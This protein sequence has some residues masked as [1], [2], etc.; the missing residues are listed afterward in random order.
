[1]RA[2]ARRVY[3]L[4]AQGYDAGRPDYPERVY[5]VLAE[6]CGAGPGTSVLEIG[7]GTGRVT[8]RLLALGARVLS[9]EPDAEMARYL[10][11]A[12]AEAPVDVLVSSFE[13]ARL[14]EE[15]FDLVVAAMSFHWVDQDVGLA[16][17]RRVLR[18]GGS[19]ALWWTS[20][21]D[22]EQPDAY[23]RAT[24][25]LLATDDAR[26]ISQRSWE[27]D[28]PRRRDDLARRAGLVDVDGELIRW[29]LRLDSSGSGPSTGR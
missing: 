5:E 15:H 24:A 6:R 14:P 27:L 2:D 29:T 21:G 23:E 4:D 25:H 28:E 22:P 13:E 17:V 3:G 10:T 7:P 8:R 1:M 19:V 9:V 18:R 12:V 16:K 11:Q 20:F 26:T